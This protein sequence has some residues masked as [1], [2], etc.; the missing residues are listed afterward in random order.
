MEEAL[1][2]NLALSTPPEACPERQAFFDAYAC[3]PFHQVRQQYLRPV[4]FSQV[5]GKSGK[6][7]KFSLR[8]LFR[9][10]KEK[11]VHSL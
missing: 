6:K 3:Q 9:R 10:K 1:A 2:E 11:K 4:S 5:I 7:D 8:S